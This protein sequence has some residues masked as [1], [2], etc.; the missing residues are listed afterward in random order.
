MRLDFV[1]IGKAF[2]HADARSEVYVELPREDHTEGK[3]GKRNSP[4]DTRDAVQNRMDAYMKAMEDEGFKKG[5]ESPCTFWNAR[6]QKRRQW[7]MKNSQIGSR[8]R[9]RTDSSVNMEEVDQHIKTT[10]R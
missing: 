9:C 5:A 8:V 4:Y 1:D 7:Y 2:F 3:F 10:T 6:G